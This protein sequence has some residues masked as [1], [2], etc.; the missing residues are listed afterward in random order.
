[1]TVATIQGQHLLQCNNDRR[2]YYS[3]TRQ[4]YC[5]NSSICYI[6][7]GTFI[8]ISHLVNG[9]PSQSSSTYSNAVIVCSELDCL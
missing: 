9:A 7:L 8:G 2:G 1:M 5:T 6:L 3:K 4:F